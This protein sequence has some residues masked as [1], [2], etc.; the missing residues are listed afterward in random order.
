MIKQN[1]E[2][3]KAFLKAI[4]VIRTCIVFELQRNGNTTVTLD[5]SYETLVQPSIFDNQALKELKDVMGDLL[6]KI[7]ETS[8]SKQ[9]EEQLERLKKEEGEQVKV[10]AN[11]GKVQANADQFQDVTLVIKKK[12][13]H[14]EMIKS[15]TSTE[16]V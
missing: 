13:T 12:R 5:T 4:E 16:V 9:I 15:S 3:S 10:D 8:E 7:Q 2:A 14:E 1:E 6:S 11:F